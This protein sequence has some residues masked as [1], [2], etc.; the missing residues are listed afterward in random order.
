MTALLAAALLGSVADVSL[1]V[2]VREADLIVDAEI[3][4]RRADAADLRVVEVLKGKSVDSVSL[5]LRQTFACDMSPAVPHHGRGLFFLERA[6]GRRVVAWAGRGVMMREGD[7][8]R[9]TG[10]VVVPRES[11]LRA[12]GRRVTVSWSALLDEVRRL[13]RGE[14][15]FPDA[16]WSLERLQCSACNLTARS[17]AFRD[18]GVF[19]W[20]SSDSEAGQK[21][22]TGRLLAARAA[23]R[24]SMAL[25]AT[26][27]ESERSRVD[28]TGTL[29]VAY[30]NGHVTYLE[31]ERIDGGLEGLC[32]NVKVTTFDCS[33][34]EPGTRRPECLEPR[35]LATCESS[36]TLVSTSPL[37]ARSTSCTWSGCGFHADGWAL[38]DRAPWGW[39]RS[40]GDRWSCS[41][42][43]GVV[44]DLV[45]P[46]SW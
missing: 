18:A 30:G 44:D 16:G 19:D 24:S 15:R 45:T 1:P 13:V 27:W 3:V 37:D 40:V 46:G 43:A 10:G 2:L 11:V 23:G 36:A 28:H 21:W 42:D 34:L 38:A 12:D 5:D 32:P 22:Q 14:V 41:T 39:C 17:D 26:P 6:S 20:G 4:S 25:F 7:E 35:P 8:A 29:V 33:G 31:A 9:V